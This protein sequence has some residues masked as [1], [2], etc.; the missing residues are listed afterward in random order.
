LVHEDAVEGEAEDEE[1]EEA[2][3]GIMDH[4]DTMDHSGVIVDEVIVTILVADVEAVDEVVSA[5]DLGSNLKMEMLPQCKRHLK[6]VF[7]IANL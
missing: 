6:A 2:E 5:M 7:Q 4:E 3:D 1:E